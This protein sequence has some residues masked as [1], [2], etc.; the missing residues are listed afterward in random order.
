MSVPAL[1]VFDEEQL[2]YETESR[3][4]PFLHKKLWMWYFIKPTE[5]LAKEC[6]N[7]WYGIY[8]YFPS[9]NTS[10]L[11]LHDQSH[12]LQLGSQGE[13]PGEGSSHIRAFSLRLVLG[14]PITQAKASV[15]K[16]CTKRYP[17]RCL[18]WDVCEQVKPE[19]LSPSHSRKVVTLYSL[20]SNP[21]SSAP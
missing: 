1:T 3:I 14:V 17:Q 13:S 4:S 5:T 2:L 8:L 6:S 10:F 18:G 19:D 21:L 11:N 7:V 9:V 15:Y 16:W 20:P 12:L